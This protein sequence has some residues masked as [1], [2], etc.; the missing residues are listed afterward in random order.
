MFVAFKIQYIAVLLTTVYCI[1]YIRTYK[2]QKF[3]L[4]FKIYFRNI[5][6]AFKI[7][8]IEIK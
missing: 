1:V 8:L 5:V 7:Y 3:V 6:I 4:A 2:L